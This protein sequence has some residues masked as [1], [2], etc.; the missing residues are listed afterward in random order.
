[1]RRIFWAFLGLGVG[2]A[3]TVIAAR[4]AR[5]QRQR[6]APAAIGREVKGGLIDL[7]RLVTESIA[8]GERAM[9]EREE[10]LRSEAPQGRRSA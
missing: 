6:L 8:E 9:R 1:M 3:S 4:F 10:R 5:R 7:A 2:V